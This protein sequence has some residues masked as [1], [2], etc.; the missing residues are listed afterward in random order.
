MLKKEWIE[1]MNK[2]HVAYFT[3]EVGLNHKIPTYS[4]GLGILAGD[5]LKAFADL[6][7]PV[8][9]VTLLNEKGYFYQRLD[10]EG[11]QIEDP[12]H[13]SLNDFLVQLP[14]I[15]TIRIDNRDVKI[16]AWK[17]TLTGV[18]GSICIIFLDTNVE[19]NSDYDRTFTSYLYGGDKY[20]RLCQEVILGIGGIRMLDSLGYNKL[21]KYHMNEGH[22]ALLTLELLKKTSKEAES[23]EKSYDM[24]AVRD[25]CVFTTHW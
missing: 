15:V 24:E 19:G 25:K 9:C 22:A 16:R 7:F 21:I 23:E 17:H 11:N 1:D 6:G 20:Y 13:W 2:E 5:T 12:V 10:N 4:G 18:N 3:M 8:I 14:N